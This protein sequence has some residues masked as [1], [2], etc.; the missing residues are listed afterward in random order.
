MLTWQ[1]LREE[2]QDCE[3]AL[4]FVR[5]DYQW[6]ASGTYYR[7]AGMLGAAKLKQF[8]SLCSFAGTKL[9]E[10]QP[11]E[12]SEAVLALSSPVDR[13][14]EALRQYSGLFITGP[15]ARQLNEDGSSA[16]HIFTGSIH[17][18]VQAS[19]ICALQ[20]SEKPVKEVEPQGWLDRL[21]KFLSNEL[22]Q[23]RYFWGFIAFV[24][25]TIIA[26]LGLA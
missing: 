15:I 23:R 1:K 14:Y 20:L 9:S 16:G 5:I 17:D 8:E 24:V 10:I 2:F 22:K 18:P 11:E 25:A 13:W 26:I 12:I 7:P 4:R 21:E 6:G 19:V 3:E